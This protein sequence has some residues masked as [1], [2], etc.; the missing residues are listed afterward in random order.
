MAVASCGELVGVH[1]LT[2][3]QESKA[4]PVAAAEGWLNGFE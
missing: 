4:E 1:L 3:P 2:E